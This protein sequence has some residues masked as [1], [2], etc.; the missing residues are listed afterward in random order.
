VTVVEMYRSVLWNRTGFLTDAQT[1]RVM[2][3]SF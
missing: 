3:T 2:V 1:H